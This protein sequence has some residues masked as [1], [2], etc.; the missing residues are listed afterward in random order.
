[1]LS[2]FI[3]CLFTGLRV[4]VSKRK[5]AIPKKANAYSM[6]DCGLD[7]S[8]KSYSYFIYRKQVF[9][10][11]REKER[12]RERR[13]HCTIQATKVNWSISAITHVPKF[14]LLYSTST[15]WS[16]MRKTVDSYRI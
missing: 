12:E 5:N 3:F 10:L 14:F 7:V 15:G 1:M 16:E 8:T 9:F 2:L 6:W 11:S 4:Q 13:E